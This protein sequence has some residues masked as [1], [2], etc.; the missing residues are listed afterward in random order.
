M[1]YQHMNSSHLRVHV[2]VPDFNGE[3]ISRD[4]ISAAMAE[5]DI[6]DAG[7]DLGKEA[8]VGGI[9]GFLE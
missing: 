8:P 9:L 4:E 2:H 6:G 3:I 1:T 5:F 7:N